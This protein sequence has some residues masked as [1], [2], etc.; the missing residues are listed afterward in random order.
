MRKILNVKDK[1]IFLDDIKKIE[2]I[3]N[4]YEVW[5]KL[6]ALI[7]TMGA[8]V[9][10]ERTEVIGEYSSKCKAL[11]A[12]NEVLKFIK[13][14][15]DVT[16]NVLQEK[17]IDDGTIVKIKPF[18]VE[19]CEE[20]LGDILSALYEWGTI[21][22]KDFQDILACVETKQ[23]NVAIKI[24][25]EWI[26]DLTEDDDDDNL[27]ATYDDIIGRFETLEKNLK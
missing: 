23:Y 13:E 12:Y 3:C 9:R 15:D 24:V 1:S 20:E 10:D 27:A 16:L 2:V 26:S 8:S 4:P 25:E 5:M 22:S 18:D 6:Y 7:I 21:S 17:D 14:P 19:W 11:K